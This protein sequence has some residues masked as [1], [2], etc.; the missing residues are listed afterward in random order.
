MRL[1]DDTKRL[2]I[3]GRTGSGKTQAAGWHLSN[4]SFDIMPWIV[5]DFKYDEL[6]NDIPGVRHI[7]VKENPR[8]PGI[9]LVHPHPDDGD[10]VEAQMWKFWSDGHKGVYADEGYMVGQR[11]RAFRS[12][13]T[14]GRSK[15]IP[16]IILSQR[17]SW[18]DRFV[19]SE[20]E[21][22][23]VF[24]LQDKRDRQTAASFIGDGVDLEEPLPDFHSIYH[25]VGAHET[26]MLRPV[27]DRQTIL[28]TFDRRL[29]KRVKVL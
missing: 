1:P 28:D 16:M 14:Q 7:D 21:F 24:A 13:L 23:Q 6:L 27:P 10:A 4:R 12:L 2:S 17:P 25:D 15:T 9:Y 20:S 11:N 19:F 29:T 26:I 8:K 3:V 22:F 5:Y 18:M